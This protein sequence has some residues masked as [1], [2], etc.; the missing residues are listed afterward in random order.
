MVA[1]QLMYYGGLGLLALGVVG[2]GALLVCF[3]LAGRR[4]RQKLEAE[5][6][7]PRHT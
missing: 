6:G 5:Y 7:K 1:N 4:L 2:G 3:R